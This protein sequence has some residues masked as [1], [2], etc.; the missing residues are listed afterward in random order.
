MAVI[1][2]AATQVHGNGLA[3]ATPKRGKEGSFCEIEGQ[4]I[5]RDEPTYAGLCCSSNYHRCPT[6]RLHKDRGWQSRVQDNARMRQEAIERMYGPED[7]VVDAV[8]AGRAS[9]EELFS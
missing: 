6:W 3:E 4:V 7:P 2:W 5:D 8:V 1:C 9:P